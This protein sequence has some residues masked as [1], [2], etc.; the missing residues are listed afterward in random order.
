LLASDFPSENPRTQARNFPYTRPLANIYKMKNLKALFAIFILFGCQKSA[1]EHIAIG[2]WNRC[3]K[4]GSY[5]EYKITDQ[6]WLMLMT[7]TDH[8]WLFQNK[9]V[10]TIMV[11]S[12]FKNGLPI[13]INND[14]LVTIVQSK[15]KVVLRSTYLWD[16][17]ELNKAE[18][19]FDPIDSTNLESWKNKTLSEFKKRAELASCPDLR[20]EE[21]K[22]IPLLELNELI[23]EEIPIIEIEKK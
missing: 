18:F 7:E 19:D 14:T 20:T 1:K 23:E 17:I 11:L 4:D 16:N 8:I 13:I 2:T 15:N 6:Y 21:E 12:E 10:D 22:M 9:I 3:N 5:W